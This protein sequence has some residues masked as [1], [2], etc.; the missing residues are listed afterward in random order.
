MNNN[1]KILLVES[2]NSAGKLY[3]DRQ[4]RNGVVGNNKINKNNAAWNT[5]IKYGIKMNVGDQLT[6]SAT[7]IN[8]RGEPDASMEFSGGDLS[9][10][11]QYEAPLV[12]NIATIEY[13]YYFT[14]QRQYNINLPLINHRVAGPTQWDTPV[15]GC[16]A[17]ED[18]GANSWDSFFN[19]YPAWGLEGVAKMKDILTT[20][21][22]GVTTAIRDCPTMSWTTQLFT[23]ATK[24]DTYLISSVVTGVHPVAG[25]DL[26]E[27]VG[28]GVYVS[29]GRRPQIGSM[30]CG[31]GT[32]P[33]ISNAPFQIAFPSEKRLYKVK[34]N[35][36]EWCKASTSAGEAPKDDLDITTIHHYITTDKLPLTAQK[37]FQTPDSVAGS[38]NEQLH[39]RTGKANNW[40]DENILPYVY[41]HDALFAMA[42]KYIFGKDK[43]LGDQLQYV[44]TNLTTGKERTTGGYQWDAGT[45]LKRKAVTQVTDKFMKTVS[46]ATGRL[47]EKIWIDP[48]IQDPTG[49]GPKAE[50]ADFTADIPG[51]TTGKAGSADKGGWRGIGLAHDP[52]EDTRNPSE[53]AEPD[54]QGR[55]GADKDGHNTYVGENGRDI[56]YNDLLVGEMGRFNALNLWNNLRD[57]AFNMEA[58]I[59]A[60]FLTSGRTRPTNPILPNPGSPFY[61]FPKSWN[62]P[63]E[64][65]DENDGVEIDLKRLY[66]SSGRCVPF[67]VHN[68]IPPPNLESTPPQPDVNINVFNGKGQFGSQVVGTDNWA[69]ASTTTM[70][71][72]TT[73]GGT[74]PPGIGDFTRITNDFILNLDLAV[75]PKI[76]GLCYTT[77]I[78]ATPRSI[79]LVKKALYSAKKV[80]KFA[81]RS[82]LNNNVND[83]ESVSK[84]FVTELDH[85][86][87][88]DGGSV[89]V[90]SPLGTPTPDVSA[91]KLSLPSP[92]N[93]VLVSGVPGAGFLNYQSQIVNWDLTPKAAPVRP[94]AKFTGIRRNFANASQNTRPRRSE[95]H[96][97]YDEEL[98][99]PKNGNVTLPTGTQFKFT[100]STGKY[101]KHQDFLRPDVK[102]KEYYSTE[103]GRRIDLLDGEIDRGVGIVI[104]YPKK[105]VATSTPALAAGNFNDMNR[106]QYLDYDD[107]FQTPTSQWPGTPNIG[108]TLPV[109]G[110]T[111]ASPMPKSDLFSQ[112]DLEWAKQQWEDTPFIAFVMMGVDNP[113]NLPVADIDKFLPNSPPGD[114]F[115]FSNSFSDGEFGKIINTQRVNPKAYGSTQMTTTLKLTNTS[116]GNY[117]SKFNSLYYNIYDYYPYAVIGASDPTFNFGATSGRFEISSLH[118]P[119]YVGNGAWCD[120]DNPA[121][122]D[123]QANEEVAILNGKQSWTSQLTLTTKLVGP[124][125][126]YGNFGLSG[127]PGDPSTDLN[128]QTP[129][130]T[131]YK[132]GGVPLDHTLLN[133][134]SGGGWLG[135]TTYPPQYADSMIVIPWENIGQANEEHRIITSQSGVGIINIYVPNTKVNIPKY[136]G[137]LGVESYLNSPGV[138]LSSWTP[139]SYTNTLFYKMGFELEQLLPIAPQTQ[140]NSF[141]RSNFNKFIGY[142]GQTLMN[143]SDNMVYPFTTNGYITGTI[144]VLGQNRN[145]LGF[146][147]ITALPNTGLKPAISSHP[148]TK[149]PGQ[150]NQ[151]G[152]IGLGLEWGNNRTINLKQLPPT[153]VYEM[154]SMGG[155]NSAV[156]TKI[157]C[158]SDVLTARR[159]PKKY[160]FSYLL[161][162]SNIIQQSPNFI[163]TNKILPIPAIGYLSRNYSSSDFFYSFDSD[164]SYTIDKS[165]VMNNFDIEIRLPNGQFAQIEDNSSLIFKITRAKP[166]IGPIPGPPKPMTKD[167]LTKQEKAELAYYKSLFS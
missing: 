118:T 109:F 152:F 28:N 27:T 26:L 35:Y 149:E 94:L 38:L 65:Q 114:F 29:K 167:E 156:P 90:N 125:P 8:L 121:G 3:T 92:Y 146:D 41:E 112:D 157:T 68:Y 106:D 102:A 74:P 98:M 4:N 47:L 162:H 135:N 55:W 116:Y 61:N 80:G 131:R 107:Q 119:T 9:L 45:R 88:D 155:L 37:G 69:N 160:D 70:K 154:F 105:W 108:N 2:N 133:N 51:N 14:N 25:R 10:V 126:F 113:D 145:W 75:A 79:A 111:E 137:T 16:W 44:N 73:S 19:S 140:S 142:E 52:A 77:N 54:I 11:T 96:T 1:N 124:I 30:Y 5:D 50:W 60:M 153:D 97:F 103:L 110:G 59:R 101:F 161:I 71:I 84:Q 141:N 17:G 82:P 100:D 76:R 104:V 18:V 62:Y 115:G 32:A 99:N 12:D 67:V 21:V 139:N 58:M 78:I 120:V 148:S 72:N 7:Q 23:D 122:A 144:N 83:P 53:N 95:Y 57:R 136:L 147:T 63:F 117:V 22:T 15:Y 165:Y 43:I 150:Y 66:I 36:K 129:Q 89:N 39:E 48:D 87:T 158:E 85:G 93:V 40:D 56:F 42:D 81:S 20:P 128:Y 31:T 130:T 86:A 164:F 34:T 13:G 123:S 91:L 127:A 163:G 33:A 138:L 46:T 159:Q 24:D 49:P 134:F 143:K 64:N 166:A 6:I 151:P 132:N